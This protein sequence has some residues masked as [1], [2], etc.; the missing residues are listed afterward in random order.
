ML[1]FFNY[2]IKKQVQF[3]ENTK[4]CQAPSVT[5]LT[6]TTRASSIILVSR[7]WFP[8]SH[9]NTVKSSLQGKSSAY[10]LLTGVV[11]LK[12]KIPVITKLPAI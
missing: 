2:A 11:V 4:P 9:G 8:D 6:E 5:I 10:M 12:S 1:I 3:A 7:F